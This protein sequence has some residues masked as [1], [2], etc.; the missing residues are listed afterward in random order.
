MKR[1]N[2]VCRQ[3]ILAHIP[4]SLPTGRPAKLHHAYILDR[5]FHVLRT[6]CQW[7]NLEVFNGS[8]KTIHHYFCQWTRSHV[9]DQAFDS[10][11]RIYLKRRGFMKHVVTDTTFVKNVYGR[12]CTGRSPV[13]RGRK[14]TKVSA[15][16]DDIGTPLKILFHPGNKSDGKTLDHLLTK[17]S[18]SW[19]GKLFADKAYTSER[20]QGVAKRFGMTLVSGKRGQPTPLHDNRKRI[21]VE[22]FFGWMDKYRRLIM[23]YDACIWNF[24]SF[25]L[26]AASNLIG[27]R[28]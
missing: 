19:S 11:V 12:Q 23:R 15:L 3:V 13:D 26:L 9:F 17:A 14:A 16:V 2:S 21:V 8:W 7:R 28:V 24:R 18:L 25:H 10:I 1:M 27:G 4:V 22:H 20:C 5:I 6:G